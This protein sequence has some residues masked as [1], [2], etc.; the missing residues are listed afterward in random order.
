[1]LFRSQGELLELASQHLEQLSAGQFRFEI[2]LE[3]AQSFRV[4]D[5]FSGIPRA[6]TTLSGG[7]TFLASLSL[8]LALAEL[9]GRR[10][11][12]LQALFLDEGFGTL[13]A[14]CLDRALSALEI[15]AAQDRLIAIISHVPLIAERVEHVWVV[16]K[17]L[18]GSEILRAS[19]EMRR[20]MVRQELAIFDPRLHPLFG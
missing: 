2:V 5:L 4:L 17:T 3:D 8:A 7:E 6:V 11:G 1:M 13:S 18:H 20:E 19:E 10:G 16:R 14:E 12:Q 15:L 9:V